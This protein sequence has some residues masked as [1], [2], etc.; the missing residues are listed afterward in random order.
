MSYG[1]FNA[2][3]LFVRMAVRSI[4]ISM[5]E[6]W[7]ISTVTGGR[8][9]KADDEEASDSSMLGRTR[10]TASRACPESMA[11]ADRIY[12]LHV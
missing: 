3:S 12:P 5:Q 8:G 9:G 7:A 1:T 6:Y 2:P 11:N 10:I 4:C